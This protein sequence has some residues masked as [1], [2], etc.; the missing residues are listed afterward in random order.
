MKL[1]V[2][3]KVKSMLIYIEYK[4]KITVIFYQNYKRINKLIEIKDFKVTMF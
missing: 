3:E 4:K 2:I 1:I